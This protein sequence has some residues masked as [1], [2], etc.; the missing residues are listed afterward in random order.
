MTDK[1]NVF[2]DAVNNY[3]PLVFSAVYLK[4]NNTNDV[5]D[6]CQEV[7]IKFFKKFDEIENHR[8]W[9]YGVLRLAVFDH[10]RARDKS[11]KIDE[12]FKDVGLSFVNGFRDARIVINEIIESGDTFDT[13]EDKISII[14]PVHSQ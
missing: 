2:T 13:E 10:Y 5:Y 14:L 12:I 6:I 7:F 11:A 9:L 4:V 8:K 3:Y 1:N